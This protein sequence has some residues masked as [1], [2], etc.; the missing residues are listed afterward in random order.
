M[1]TD[2]SYG[3]ITVTLG[4]SEHSIIIKYYIQAYDQ[5]YVFPNVNTFMHTQRCSKI[6]YMKSQPYIVFWI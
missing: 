5:R 2:T 1:S 4:T 3:S 6:F